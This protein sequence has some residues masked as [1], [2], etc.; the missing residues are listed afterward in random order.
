MDKYSLDM[1]IGDTVTLFKYNN[2]NVKVKVAV[3]VSDKQDYD[4]PEWVLRDDNGSLSYFPK[5]AKNST[6]VG[7]R[8]ILLGEHTLQEFINAVDTE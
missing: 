8:T 4:V 2:G 1:K 7:D 3:I 6:L 5:G